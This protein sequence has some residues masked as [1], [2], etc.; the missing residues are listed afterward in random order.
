MCFVFSTYLFFWN[1]FFPLDDI[2][3]LVGEKKVISWQAIVQQVN[4]SKGEA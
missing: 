1:Y 3:I 4:L 2:L